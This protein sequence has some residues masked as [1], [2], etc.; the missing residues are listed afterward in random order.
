MNI[1]KITIEDEELITVAQ[2]TIK[3]LYKDGRHHVGAA[4]RTK[5]G[6]IISAVHIEAYIGRITVCAEA[7]V[8]GK[9]ISEGFNEFDA[10]V[11]V[12]HPD[13]EEENQEIKVV[14]PCGMCREL[15]NDYGEDIQVIMPF[16]HEV[17]KVHTSELLPFKYKRSN[18]LGG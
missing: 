6:E 5:T 8:I 3:K 16:E 14:S 11:A 2:N 12:R 18:H 13:V 17:A 15:L 1:Q 10:I 4:L 7:I 9:A